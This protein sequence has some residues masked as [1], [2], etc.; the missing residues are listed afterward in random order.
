MGC[1]LVFSSV[2]LTLRASEQLRPG[3]CFGAPGALA[4]AARRGRGCSVQLNQR[5]TKST[6]VGNSVGCEAHGSLLVSPELYERPWRGFGCRLGARGYRSW[7]YRPCEGV[8][9]SRICVIIRGCWGSHLWLR[10]YLN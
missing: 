7:A 5:I 9:H 8:E 2:G 6:Q 10:K 3:L 4:R 1:H